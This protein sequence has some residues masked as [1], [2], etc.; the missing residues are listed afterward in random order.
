VGCALVLRLVGEA[1]RRALLRD[2]SMR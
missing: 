1:A 2:A